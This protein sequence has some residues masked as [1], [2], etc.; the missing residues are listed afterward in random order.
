MTK[1]LVSLA[2]GVE[3]TAVNTSQFIK[4]IRERLE[5]KLA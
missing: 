3:T 1:D 4:A 2:E 5:K